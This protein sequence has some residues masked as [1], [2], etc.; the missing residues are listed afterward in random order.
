MT[1]YILQEELAQ[2][3]ELICAHQEFTDVNGKKAKLKA[4]KQFLPFHADDE[5]VEPYPHAIVRL[6]NGKTSKS[7]EENKVNVIL[8]F[9]VCD[10]S[11]EAKG[12]KSI[13]NI[14]YDI[15][16]RFVK[17]PVLNNKFIADDEII[18]SLQDNE[19]E[20]TYPYFFGGMTMTFTI[21]AFR[22]EG[23]IYT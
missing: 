17:N 7:I 4:F 11:Y 14:I 23:S 16:E 3:I 8:L 5:E 12:Y 15:H 2:E 21:P 6:D 19:I 20:E 13:L 22:R 1:P 18:W 9:G 10:K